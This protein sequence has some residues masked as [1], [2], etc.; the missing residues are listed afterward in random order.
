MLFPEAMHH[1]NSGSRPRSEKYLLYAAKKHRER[2]IKT[3]FYAKLNSDRTLSTQDSTYRSE[4]SS[5]S[6][7]VEVRTSSESI[8]PHQK[9]IYL[10]DLAKKE[11]ASKPA[12]C[13]VHDTVKIRAPM[14]IS[15]YQRRGF[16]AELTNKE[17]AK[18]SVECQSQDFDGVD[19]EIAVV[20]P[21][22]HRQRR[23]F[24]SELF[25][26]R[27]QAEKQIMKDNV[28]NE[29]TEVFSKSH[30]ERRAPQSDDRDRAK[31]LEN[32]KS[33]VL[34][35]LDQN[36]NNCHALAS[37][38]K[39]PSAQIVG[40]D[41]HVSSA[42]GNKAATNQVP[43]SK[44]IPFTKKSNERF[45]ERLAILKSIAEERRAILERNDAAKKQNF[46]GEERKEQKETGNFPTTPFGLMQVIGEG[47]SHLRPS[48]K[49]GGVPD[50]S[51]L[52]SDSADYSE[53][54]LDVT[55]R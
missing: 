7:S 49:C 32:T 25:F 42:G 19:G 41:G 1:R 28:E 44:I 14:K 12:E 37:T 47:L 53:V 35:A 13:E 20:S 39:T 11:A 52:D 17:A 36:Y 34:D 43:D 21:K 23:A 30:I 48:T 33:G 9:K 2:D 29:G 22:S 38:G 18:K 24:V 55:L 4:E 51:L 16:I 40:Q 31:N 50:I 45:S 5:N 54:T 8:A 6:E 3:K 10:P 15:A 46:T 27:K 26:A